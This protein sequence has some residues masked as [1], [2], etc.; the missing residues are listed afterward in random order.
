MCSLGERSSIGIFI[1]RDK[2]VVDS[3]LIRDPATLAV[4]INGS[5]IS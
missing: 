1:L 5:A 4:T 2:G 3:H